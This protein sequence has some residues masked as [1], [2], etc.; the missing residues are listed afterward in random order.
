MIFVNGFQ[1]RHLSNR[2]AG[3]ILSNIPNKIIP[4]AFN[5]YP[6]KRRFKVKRCF[7]ALIML[8][9]ASLY[10]VNVYSFDKISFGTYTAAQ[11][12]DYWYN[13]GAEISRFNLHQMRYGEIHQGDAVL[14]FVTEEMN[15]AIQ[16]KADNPGPEDIPMLKLNAVRKFFT[17][18]YPY[19]IMTS[20]FSPV[21]IQK[22]PLP[23]KISLST[24]E[25][26][27]NVYTQMN[28]QNADYRVRLHSYFEKEGDQDFTV[29]KYTPEDAVWNIIRIAPQDLPQGEFLMIPGTAYARLVHHPLEP[30]KAVAELEQDKEKSLEGNP[31][32]RYEL[33]FPG[34]QRT[35]RIFFEKDFPYRI[36]KWE[37]SYPGLAGAAGK[38]L[39]TRAVRTHTIMDSY[40]Q[41]HRNKDREL[42]KK[43]GLSAREM[44]SD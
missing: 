42:L 40:W 39:T 13:H 34:E 12:R 21:D 11:F 9:S 15:P 14:V 7:V 32:V 35:L 44:G 1:Y 29:K 26:C 5:G 33:N 36:Q 3:I 2:H 37:E 31:L 18:I 43:L 23:L 6:K 24:Q 10:A 4:I 19:S 38:D 27:G 17:G 30:Q 41:H 8:L 22:Y 25:W 20:I 28:L 16:V